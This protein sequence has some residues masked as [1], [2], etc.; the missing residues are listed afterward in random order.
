[1]STIKNES[2]IE[3]VLREMEKPEQIESLHFLVNKLPELTS[4]IQFVEEKVK[5]IQYTISDQQ[6]VEGI[7]GQV[8]Q[9]IENLHLTKEHLEAMV[10]MVQA[11]PRLVQY[12]EKAEDMF[13]FLQNVVTDSESIEYAL[14]GVKEVPPVEK[15]LNVLKE[16]NERFQVQQDSSPVSMLRMYR[17]LKHPTIQSGLKYVETLLDVIHKQK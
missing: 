2:Q 10:L 1:M 14:K 6:S 13:L 12:L 4:A 15:T 5:F 8:E 17:L 16:T 9:K 3:A 11:L 7:I